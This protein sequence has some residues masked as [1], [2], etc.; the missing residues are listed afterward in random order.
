MTITSFSVFLGWLLVQEHT[1]KL[2]PTYLRADALLR[3]RKSH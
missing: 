2:M 1:V 3:L